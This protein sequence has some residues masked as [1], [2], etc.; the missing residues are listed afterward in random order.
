MEKERDVIRRFQT[1]LNVDD[2]IEFIQT[3]KNG[4]SLL[5]LQKKL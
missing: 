4:I 5:V 3:L 1:I 2:G